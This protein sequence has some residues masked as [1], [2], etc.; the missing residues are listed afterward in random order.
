MNPMRWIT[1]G[2]CWVAASFFFE[3]A[4]TPPTMPPPTSIEPHLVHIA[5][6]AQVVFQW[7]G[8]AQVAV[9]V[10]LALFR[11]VFLAD[12]SWFN[13]DLH[14]WAHDSGRTPPPCEP[15]APAMPKDPK[16]PRPPA[17]PRVSKPALPE[18]TDRDSLI[19]SWVPDEC[20]PEEREELRPYLAEIYGD[21][22][23]AENHK[24]FEK[25]RRK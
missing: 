8:W 21:G 4:K 7:G 10:G 22:G 23:G 20:S 5:E 19:D 24:L 1:G 16:P 2:V 13:E 15:W 25:K 18:G 14:G 17:P 11:V 9:G 12:L 6:T 3:F